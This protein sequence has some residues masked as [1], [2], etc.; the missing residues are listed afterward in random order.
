MPAT[1]FKLIFDEKNFWAT[2]GLQVFFGPSWAK[3]QKYLDCKNRLRMRM[4][5][6]L[7]ITYHS[8]V[9]KNKIRI[10][11]IFLGFICDFW[12]N[13]L[14]CHIYENDQRLSQEPKILEKS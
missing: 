7:L 5:H 10:K 3:S 6:F 11:F 1:G 9:N 14:S 4:Y 12:K 2:F 8:I 13:D